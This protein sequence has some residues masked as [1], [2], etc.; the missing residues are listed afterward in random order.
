MKTVRRL[1]RI[2]V[3]QLAI[4]LS[5]LIALTG[6]L[7]QAWTAVPA[8]IITLALGAV[9]GV[10]LDRLANPGSPARRKPQ[11]NDKR[12]AQTPKYLPK[13][14][15]GKGKKP[16]QPPARAPMPPFLQFALQWTASLPGQLFTVLIVTSLAFFVFIQMGGKSNL[17]G[18][19]ISS[20]KAFFCEAS[21][22]G[23]APDQI[24]AAKW[25]EY[26]YEL[27]E[28]SCRD[29]DDYVIELAQGSSSNEADMRS[30]VCKLTQETMMSSMRKIVHFGDIQFLI[31]GEP[32]SLRAYNMDVF[33]A[34]C[35]AP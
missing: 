10:G 28:N 34:R 26:E 5:G 7:F 12:S 30:E 15:P 22:V 2:H 4:T 16:G 27:R 17:A 24:E 25:G 33:T 8:A 20:Q 31:T 18:E 3:Y 29:F 13:D 9:L 21:V 19:M 6:L 14:G 35:A 23:V 32:G 11:V 1:S